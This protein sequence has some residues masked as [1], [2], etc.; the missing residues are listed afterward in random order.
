MDLKRHEKTHASVACI[1][2][3]EIHVMKDKIIDEEIFRCSECDKKFKRKTPPICRF[4]KAGH[5]MFGPKGQNKEGK[6]YKRHPAPCQKYEAGECDD[7]AC[8]YMHAA[9]VCTF[10]LKNKC[11]KN[12]VNLL[13]Q[14]IKLRQIK[15]KMGTILMLLL[16]QI[17]QE[18]GQTLSLF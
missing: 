12:T 13:T 11:Q 16:S 7:K 1:D 3:G 5:C 6:C 8:T 9:P 10:F 15:T 14:E 18:T 17:V 2:C 4:Y